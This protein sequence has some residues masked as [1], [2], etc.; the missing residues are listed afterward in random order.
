VPRVAAA[1]GSLHPPAD[2]RCTR[3]HQP[4]ASATSPF[5]L[6]PVG[7]LCVT[8]HQGIGEQLQTERVHPPAEGEGACLTCHGPTESIPE[9]VRAA[10][11]ERY[12]DDK[13][14]GYAVGD[15][16]GA[17]WAESVTTP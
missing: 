15:L 11:R 7:P 17:L 1:G 9:D 2:D 4:H 8:C 12:P 5:L 13:A 6:A 3:C 16:R 14:T 10:L